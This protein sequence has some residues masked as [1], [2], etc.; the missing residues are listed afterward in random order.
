M[1][2]RTLS[3]DRST[4]TTPS[5]KAAARRP[6]RAVRQTR[7]RRRAS[8]IEVV[9]VGAQG[10]VP[11]PAWIGPAKLSADHGGGGLGH[12]PGRRGLAAADRDEAVDPVGRVVEAL[13]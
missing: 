3:A 5:A 10:H 11:C 6:G 12:R 1:T 4:A 8:R 13:E 2:S 9:P 7:N